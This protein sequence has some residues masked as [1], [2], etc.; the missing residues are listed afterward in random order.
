ME[1]GSEESEEGMEFL[2][3]DPSK[4]FGEDITNH[5]IDG[6]IVQY[7]VTGGKVNVDMLCASV[8]SGILRKTDGALIIT[9]KRSGYCKSKNWR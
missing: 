5:V 2:K 9:E 4:W 7:D 8:K 3:L 6:T 1:V